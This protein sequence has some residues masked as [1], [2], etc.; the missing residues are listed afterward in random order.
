MRLLLA[1][2]GSAALAASQPEGLGRVEFPA[3]GSA[4][5]H[6]H[7]F[8]GVAALH[9]FEYEQAIAAFQQA[10]ATDPAFV[11]AYWGE[12]LAYHSS[13][14]GGEA[15][16]RARAALSRLGST[17]AQRLARAPTERE[18]GFL[19]AIEAL[20]GEGDERAR[21]RAYVDAMARLHARWPDDDEAA[22]FYAHALLEQAMR[23]RLAPAAS[24][25]DPEGTSTHGSHL[26]GTDTQRRVGDLLRAVLRRNPRHP[27]A[28]HYLLHN[29]DDPEH[30]HLA[31][32]VARTYAQ[33]APASSHARHMP[34]HIFVQL[35]LWREAAASDEAASAAAEA[36]ARRRGADEAQV[37]YHP[38]TWLQ[39]ERLQLGQVARAAALTERMEAR[40]R[41]SAAPLLRGLAATLRARLVVETQQWTRLRD[42]DD[43]GSLDELHAIGLSAARGGRL[44][45]AADVRELAARYA[46]EAPP[47]SPPAIA[48]EAIARQVEGLLAA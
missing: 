32:D 7:F 10:R 4:D 18:R 12:A 47:G 37:D 30:A 35:G 27:G 36:A 2:I 20:L 24:G 14:A 6:R 3:S 26:A 48:L 23:G 39:Y 22:S 40:A 5:A 28:A 16:A 31:I 41:Q 15:L 44:D 21:L 42:G 34:A 17:P 8:R 43:F 9:N 38:L 13:L 19:E 1:V 46:R 33:I 11:M 29:Y 45:R 25:G